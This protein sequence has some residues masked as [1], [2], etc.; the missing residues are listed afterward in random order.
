[1]CHCP[2][3]RR[4]EVLTSSASERDLGNRVAADGISYY[5]MVRLQSGRLLT[6]CHWCPYKKTT[7]SRRHLDTEG[8][9]PWGYG[10]KPGN[11]WVPR[12]E[13][14]VRG[15]LPEGLQGWMACLHLGFRLRPPERKGGNLCGR[16]PPPA[17]QGTSTQSGQRNPFSRLHSLNLSGE[18][19]PKESTLKGRRK[20]FSRLLTDSCPPK[21]R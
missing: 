2:P 5:R 19:W 14:V 7:A 12:R 3:K 17:A 6:Q 13:E 15:A 9:W 11:V 16:P 20:L 4:V 1:M 21:P 18:K 8:R 10:C